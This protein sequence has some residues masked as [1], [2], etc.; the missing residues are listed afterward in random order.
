MGGR[1]TIVNSVLTA[2]PLYNM[3]FLPMP[4]TVV[5]QTK[6]MQCNF[7]WGGNDDRKKMAW[8]KWDDLYKHKKYGGLGIKN[9]LA[10]NKALLGK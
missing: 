3:S 10:F 2:M 1:I 7:L 6:A 5:N 8:I 4:K 9:L